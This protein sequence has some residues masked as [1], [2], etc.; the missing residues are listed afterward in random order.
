MR[1]RR[2]RPEDQIQRAVI[3]HLRQRKAP[4]TWFCHVPM[5][6]KRRP[7][8]AAIL[9][10]LGSVAGTPDLL[11]IRDGRC[12]GL[13]LK[14]ETGKASEKQRE[15]IA[16]MQNAGAVCTVTYGLNEAIAWLE[17]QGILLGRMSA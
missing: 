16:A 4:R 11:I 1:M 8:E 6:G 17:Q 7:I 10:G 5:G 3:A 2:A 15:T 13:E 14:S 12:Y 9:K